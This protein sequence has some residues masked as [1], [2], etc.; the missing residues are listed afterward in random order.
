MSTHKVAAWSHAEEFITPSDHVEDAQRRAEEL[1]VGAVGNGVG[2]FLS[3]LAAAIGAKAVM[4]VGTGAGV[5]GLWL[6]GGMPSD[7]ILTTIDLEVEHQHA[8]REAFAAAGVAHQRT[9]VI[10]GRALEVLPRMTDGAYDLVVVDADK[11]EYPLY[12]EQATRL[13]RA[14]GTLALSWTDQESDPAIRDPETRALR[15]VGR[16]LRDDARFIV[17]LLPIG[18]GLLLAVKR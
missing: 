11:E 1:G 18:D 3:A 12:V 6:L 15:D 10:A 2:S 8:A 5:S 16:A 13:L 17:S 9:R 14:G 7:G 4:E